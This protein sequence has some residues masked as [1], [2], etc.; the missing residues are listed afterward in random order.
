MGNPHEMNDP[1]DR[2]FRHVTDRF[3]SWPVIFFLAS[4]GLT[5]LLYRY[6]TRLLPFISDDALISLRYTQR[7]L[8]GHGLT[9]TDG[10]A[11]E[12]Y[13]N[14]LW[15]LL[16]AVPGLFGMDLILGLRVLGIA[17]LAAVPLIVLWSQARESRTKL[18]FTALLFTLWPFS[19]T[20]ATWAIGGLEQPLQGALLASAIA[21]LLHRPASGAEERGP[22]TDDPPH[23]GR[24]SDPGLRFAG[25]FLGLSALTR[26]DGY[27]WAMSFAVAALILRRGDRTRREELLWL[28]LVPFL[29]VL[30]QLLFRVLYYGDWLP[31]T[32]RVKLPE[33][34]GRIPLGLEYMLRAFSVQLLYWIPVAS[35]FVL[36]LLRTSTRR[37]AF[38]L[39]VIFLPWS[40]Y[41]IIIGGD[42]FPS[43][44]QTLPLQVIGLFLL[45][46]AVREYLPMLRRRNT[47]LILIALLALLLPVY[48][49]AYLSRQRDD[50]FMKLAVYE[51]W[52]WDG[53]IIAETLRVVFEKDQPHIAVTA[54][55]CIPYFSGFPSIDMLGLNDS[56]IARQPRMDFI[57]GGIGHDHQDPAYLLERAPD[58]VLFTDGSGRKP[59]FG[60]QDAFGPGSR[61]QREYVPVL[62]LGKVS[63]RYEPLVWFRLDSPKTGIR[64]DGNR[65]RIPAY[66][67]ERRGRREARLGADNR[68]FT[69]VPARDSV[70]FILPYSLRD[71]T[72]D[73]HAVDLVVDDEQAIDT[74]GAEIHRDGHRLV[75]RAGA[76]PLHFRGV[77]LSCLVSHVPSP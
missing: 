48:L 37:L 75:I 22:G 20:V 4:A 77:T 68:F 27:L 30:A 44:R 59:E 31:N 24:S 32:A 69:L 17:L 11:V 57:G 72:I 28:L 29:F 64:P 36:L 38:G 55:G 50:Y 23:P 61:F 15:V 71:C 19:V 45:A 65:Y 52:E 25:L 8:E 13:S 53:K 3:I 42:G 7:L 46:A 62:V 26:P 16:A 39:L 54:A 2:R 43:Y 6:A 67:F 70:S 18:V 60:Y 66:F 74:A 35:A 73:P 76:R 1:R 33:D 63:L 10:P 47:R 5:V 9:W 41:I 14:L 56:H 40:L 49:L 51:R 12:G 58:L 34:S 21:A